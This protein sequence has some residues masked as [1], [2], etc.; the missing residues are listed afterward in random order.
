MLRWFTKN[1]GIFLLAFVLAL[2]VWVS[3]IT[4]S[5]PDETRL[6]PE[7]VPIEFIGQDPGLIRT[8]N[9]PSSVKVTL[10]APRSVWNQL[11][12]DEN[13]VR[14]IADLTG[15]S[16]GAHTLKLQIQV[17]VQPVKIISVEPTLLRISLEDIDTQTF[18]VELAQ[19]GTPAVGYQ[20]G[21]ATLEPSEAVVSGPESLVHQV[22]SLR[23]VVDLTAARQNVETTLPLQAINENGQ[24]LAGLTLHPASIQVSLPVIQQGGYRDLA[25]KVVVTGRVASGYRLASISAFPPVIT[26]H[27]QDPELVNKLPGY[28]ETEP[29]DLTEVSANIET[30]LALVLPEGVTLVGEQTVLVQVGISPIEG[31]LT[32]TNRPLEIINLG[33][34]L[35]AQVSP[36]AVD[37]ILSGPLPL[38]DTLRATDIHVVIDVTGLGTGTYQL[39]PTV[40]IM[41]DGIVVES[42][43]PGTVEV[44]ITGQTTPT[45]L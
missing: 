41:I 15:L 27:S 10:R 31:S 38:L 43:L 7:N 1:V 33:P 30:R 17:S 32:L 37:V 5:D 39:T 2:A 42:I 22:A 14:A 8:G 45:P 28:V 26:V 4:A 25:V 18:T 23:V 9:P 21:D 11:D 20:V 3:A 29:L 34:G 19:T 16:A 6:Y 35:A 40:Q 36:A 12:L 24:V 13:A 44:I